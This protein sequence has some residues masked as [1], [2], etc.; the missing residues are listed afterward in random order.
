MTAVCGE[1][2]DESAACMHP[3]IIHDGA[4]DLD[5]LAV[6]SSAPAAAPSSSSSSSSSLWFPPLP[7]PFRCMRATLLLFL[8]RRSSFVKPSSVPAPSPQQYTQQSFCSSG[9]RSCI[10][11]CCC[12]C[13]FRWKRRRKWKCCWCCR[14]R[15]RRRAKPASP[16]LSNRARKKQLPPLALSLPPLC[17]PP[18]LPSSSSASHPAH[19]SSPRPLPHS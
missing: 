10:R 19:S 9:K 8:F 6:L 12:C 4:S 18:F 11:S 16:C 3:P 7:C 5:E 1:R 13:C 2:T 17:C 14:R 15:R